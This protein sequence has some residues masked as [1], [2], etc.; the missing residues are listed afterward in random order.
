MELSLRAAKRVSSRRETD[1]TTRNTSKTTQWLF[2][3]LETF[4]PVR[5]HS[6]PNFLEKIQ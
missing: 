4:L 6:N 2:W 5:T 3:Q 1:P